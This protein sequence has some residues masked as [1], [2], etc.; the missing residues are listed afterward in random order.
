MKRTIDIAESVYAR[1]A[2]H[3]EGFDTPSDVITR[4]LDS[5]ES[6]E[7][8]V[9][10]AMEEQPPGIKPRV[11]PSNTAEPLDNAQIQMRISRVLMRMSTEDL[12]PFCNKDYSKQVFGINFPLLVKVPITADAQARKDAVKDKEVSRWTWKF[13]FN[14]GNFVYAICTNWYRSHDDKVKQWLKENEH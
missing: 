3:A 12:E 14:K 10:I 2:K 9:R 7:T 13:S 8:S 6:A 4:L 5:F 1:L 11:R